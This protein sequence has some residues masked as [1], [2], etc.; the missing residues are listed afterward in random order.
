M[1]S[2][3]ETLRQERFRKGFDLEQ[4]SRETKIST[5]FLEYIE[6]EQWDKLPGGV[7]TKNF[8][9]QYARALKLDDD[10]I[11]HELQR[12]FQPAPAE[13]N[14]P[15]QI[16][17]L[18]EIRLPRVDVSAP[19]RRSSSSLPAFAL[20]VAVMLLCSGIYTWWQRGA[21]RAAAKDAA[22]IQTQASPVQQPVPQPAVAPLQPVASVPSPQPQTPPPAGAQQ[23]PVP[24]SALQ[25]PVAPAPQDATIVTD[26]AGN[27][28]LGIRAEEPTWV[29][30]RSDGKQVYSGTLQP[31]ESKTLVAA[32]NI[33]LV[34]GNAG[35]IGLTLNGQ[36][37]PAVGP[38]GQVRVVEVTQKGVQIVPR[39]P[40]PDDD[41]L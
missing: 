19:G 26:A 17:P 10:E 2:I 33:K 16:S 35:G 12:L 5:R 9:R 4:V 29:S 24:Q 13:Q 11:A 41:S 18:D 36:A 39:N 30:I 28:K 20:V 27:V 14:E 21:H 34:I 6:N 8:V 38:R 15:P 37:V 32:E 23:A 1:T 22:R 25:Q 31:N 3:G 40:T 7:F